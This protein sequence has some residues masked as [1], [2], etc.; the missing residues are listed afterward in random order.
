MI[1]EALMIWTLAIFWSPSILL[2]FFSML[3]PI[4]LTVIPQTYDKH[5]FISGTFALVLSV[6]NNL[7]Q[8]IHMAYFL[9]VQMSPP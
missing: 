7:S 2:F 5:I 3:H 6:W 9:F 1:Y 4:S 8:D